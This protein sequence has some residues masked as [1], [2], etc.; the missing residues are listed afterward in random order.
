MPRHPASAV[1]HGY[2]AESG[3]TRFMMPWEI[4]IFFSVT[5]CREMLVVLCG[6]RDDCVTEGQR[7]LGKGK[8]Q[9][10]RYKIIPGDHGEA[11]DRHAESDMNLGQFREQLRVHDNGGHDPDDE[12]D[13]HCRDFG[14][15]EQ[16]V[17]DDQGD[18]GKQRRCGH[19]GTPSTMNVS[20]SPSMMPRTTGLVAS[21]AIGLIIPVTPARSQKRP[22]VRPEP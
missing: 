2:A 17:R 18:T 8:E 1:A 11:K 14:V 7:Y 10:A 20:P 12:E 15:G 22:V 3:A 21:L 16:Q 19:P 4:A 9:G 5:A 13:E 6:D